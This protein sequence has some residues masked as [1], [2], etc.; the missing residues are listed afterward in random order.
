MNDVIFSAL[1]S[2]SLGLC[3]LLLLLSLMISSGCARD[4]Q[5]TT[6]PQFSLASAL[7]G[8]PIDSRDF[9]DKVLIINFFATG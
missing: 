7:G 8:N 2:R 5:I 9:V 1:R 6:L 4:P 3:G